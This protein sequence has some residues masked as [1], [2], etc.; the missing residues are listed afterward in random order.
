MFAELI[1][2]AANGGVGVGFTD[3][4]GGVS[5]GELAEFNLGRTDLDAPETLRANMALLRARVGVQ[6]VVVVHQVHGVAVYQPDADQ[7]DWSHDAWLGDR[8]PGQPQ[9]P[10][11]DA[12]IT[13][14]P[15]LGLA[16]RVADCVPVL[17][18]DPTAGLIGAAHA[19][20][21]GLLGG[22]LDATVAALQAHGAQE[23]TAWIGP[24]ICGQCYEVPAQMAAE[25]AEQLPASAAT[26][27]WGTPAIDLG[28]GAA[29]RLSDLGVRVQRLDDR[30]TRT[31]ATLYSHRGDGP[32][33]GRQI[34]LIWLAD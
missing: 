33:T 1:E 10:I 21:V 12:S 30:C 13:S 6:Q 4:L 9:L 2:P 5:A 3:R 8:V 17:F 32:N 23:L 14:R 28:A 29:A 27:S 20:R 31:D 18:A 15:G 25:A 11:A 16:I 22:V 24:H 7:R 34:G 19:G 26:T